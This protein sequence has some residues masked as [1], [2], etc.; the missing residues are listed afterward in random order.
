MALD[1]DKR[2][3]VFSNLNKLPDDVRKRLEKEFLAAYLV[4]STTMEKKVSFSLE[5]AYDFVENGIYSLKNKVGSHDLQQILNQKKAFDFMLEKAKEDD[6]FL[7]EDLIK[8]FHEIIMEGIMPGGVYRNV[9]IRI[10]GS[11]HVPTNYMRVYQKMEEF[12]EEIKTITDPIYL[13]SFVHGR[14]DK[15]H[16][17]LDG[18]GRCSRLVVNYVLVKN[19]LL[20][21]SV[22]EKDKREYF[23]ALEEYKVNRNFD[24]LITLFSRLENERLDLYYNEIKSLERN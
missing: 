21:I 18:N 13:A 24:P 14:L 6:V 4:D 11:S 1:L 19:N 23:D 7:S 17:F 2:D 5:E 15:I 20:P 16:P 12:N 10:Q 3:F 9:D 8:K 22:N